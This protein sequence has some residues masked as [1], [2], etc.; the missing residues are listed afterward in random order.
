MRQVNL[1]ARE[2][3]LTAEMHKYRPGGIGN[4][5]FH[6]LG[7]AE[8]DFAQIVGVA[9]SPGI[10]VTQQSRIDLHLRATRRKWVRVAQSEDHWKRIMR[11][12]CGLHDHTMSIDQMN[13]P[14]DAGKGHWSAFLHL[15]CDAIRQQAHHTGR[16]DPWN[17]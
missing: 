10:Q 3:L 4:C 12:A 9:I 1:E 2:K 11:L 16:L 8:V 13:P 5:D 6:I 14:T 17:L 7:I 15:D